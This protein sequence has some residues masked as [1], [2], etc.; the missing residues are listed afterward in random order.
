MGRS[1]CGPPLFTPTCL[2]EYNYFPFLKRTS[3][4]RKNGW[5]KGKIMG[6]LLSSLFNSGEEQH[7]NKN[8][9]VI[10]IHSMTNWDEHWTAN[11]QD[12]NNLV[13]DLILCISPSFF[14]FKDPFTSNIGNQS[15]NPQ[16]L[17]DFTAKWCGPCRFI[18]P[19]F[20]AFSA[21]YTGVAFL[22]VDVDELP[23]LNCLIL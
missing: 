9:R 3:S 19:T 4:Q 17:I 8:S 12:S 11:K 6:S 2:V 13:S 22:K 14:F 15:V 23:V 16:M 18:G 7:P 10:A 5:G 20:E 21:Q 1:R